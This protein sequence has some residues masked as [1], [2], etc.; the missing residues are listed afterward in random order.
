MFENIELIL[1]VFGRP[2]FVLPVELPKEG[3]IVSVQHEGLL[4]FTA[5]GCIGKVGSVDDALLALVA[6]QKEVGIIVYP[7]GSTSPCPSCLTH[8]AKVDAREIG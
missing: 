4:F 2:V 3:C 1:D 6:S 8:I 7:E 5:Q